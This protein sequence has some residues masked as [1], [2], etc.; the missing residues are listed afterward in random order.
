MSSTGRAVGVVAVA[1][2]QLNRHQYAKILSAF[3]E[4]LATVPRS[5][6]VNRTGRLP[7]RSDS[8][9]L[10]GGLGEERGLLVPAEARDD[11]CVGVHD[12]VI[13]AP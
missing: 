13:R 7:P 10:L 1:Q 12:F 11:L 2:A 9:Q 4:S 8:V 3:V 6:A 5:M